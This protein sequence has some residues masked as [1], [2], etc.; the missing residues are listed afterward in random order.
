MYSIEY[1]QPF[2]SIN[3]KK[4]PEKYPVR[5]VHLSTVNL[6]N[7]VLKPRIPDSRLDEEDNTVKRVCFS[8]CVTG[9]LRGLGQLP[10]VCPTV[11]AHTPVDPIDSLR[12][13]RP[14]RE[15]VE[16]VKST[17][18]W[19][20]TRPVRLKC[21]GQ[22][23]VS[24]DRR[25]YWFVKTA[26]TFSIHTQSSANPVT[27]DELGG[28]ETVE[29][30]LLSKVLSSR[31]HRSSVALMKIRHLI[32]TSYGGLV[33]DKE[34]NDTSNP[35]YTIYKDRRCK[36]LYI[37]KTCA[38]TPISFHTKGQSKLFLSRPEN[39]RLMFDYLS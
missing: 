24:P 21:I 2:T 29:I 31:T 39:E 4:K 13:I 37:G 15:Q 20:V 11:Y 35:V 28:K 8:S 27:W 19:W 1:A 10:S 26:D 7:R 25:H 17:R 14:T 18:E 9:A 32:Q 34:W 23:R 38:R 3:M 33:T 12:P 30:N 6:D 36:T 5:L 22:I 16:D